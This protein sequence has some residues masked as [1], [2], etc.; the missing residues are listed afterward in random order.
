[1]IVIAV[2][3]AAVVPPA[4]VEAAGVEAAGVPD[5]PAVVVALAA[6]VA[7]LPAVVVAVPAAAVVA[8]A[9]AV[10][11]ADVVFVLLLLPHAV[12]T[13]A[14]PTA[15]AATEALRFLVL[16]WWSSCWERREVAVIVR[17]DVA[18]AARE[19]RPLD[20]TVLPDRCEFRE[21]SIRT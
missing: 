3:P 12:A 1:V 5:V 2:P 19:S 11:G 20:H 14:K 15:T 10:V 13:S 16:T 21:S 8:E 18:C 9:A 17:D 6:V 7:V 4:G